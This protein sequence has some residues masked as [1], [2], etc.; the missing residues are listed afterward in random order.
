MCLPR[1]S[2]QFDGNQA[3]RHNENHY[4]LLYLV[5]TRLFERKPDTD[6]LCHF[7]A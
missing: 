3:I 4:R 1:H 2:M 6:S 5:E 7:D